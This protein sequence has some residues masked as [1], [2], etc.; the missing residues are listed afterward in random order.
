MTRVKYA[1]ILAHKTSEQIEPSYGGLIGKSSV[2]LRLDGKSM[3]S[4]GEWL[5]RCDGPLLDSAI[6]TLRAGSAPR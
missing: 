2:D 4:Q 1:P 6:Q 3:T 5:I